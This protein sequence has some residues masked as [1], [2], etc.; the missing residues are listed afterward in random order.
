MIKGKDIG[1]YSFSFMADYYQTIES[2][3]IVEE[4]SLYPKSM[5]EIYSDVNMS[6]LI[7]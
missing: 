6:A 3:K 5:A 7:S 4:S 1:N 2:G